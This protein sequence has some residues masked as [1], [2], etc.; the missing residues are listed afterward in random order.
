MASRSAARC[1][2]RD[3]VCAIINLLLVMKK[4]CR[5]S[6]WQAVLFIIPVDFAAA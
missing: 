4:A 2:A 5:L 6:R 3:R 1:F